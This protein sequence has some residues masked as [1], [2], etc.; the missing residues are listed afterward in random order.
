MYRKENERLSDTIVGEAVIELLDEREPITSGQ[1]LLKLQTFLLAAE[2]TWREIAIR[3]A[4][5][6]V[7][8][9]VGNDGSRTLVQ[10]SVLH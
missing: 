3:D 2:E 6:S 4:I 5:R 10:A 9:E 1:L 7:Q 8:A